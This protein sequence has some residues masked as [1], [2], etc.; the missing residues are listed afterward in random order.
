MPNGRGQRASQPK[1]GRA[2][3]SA[4][5]VVVIGDFDCGRI[6]E[7]EKTW[8]QFLYGLTSHEHV[9]DRARTY[10]KVYVRLIDIYIGYAGLKVS[11]C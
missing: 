11:L 3:L 5:T 10:P 1:G 8:V 2:Q 4:P 9:I 7:N 6:E